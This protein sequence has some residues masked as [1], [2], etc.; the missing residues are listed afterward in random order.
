M[1]TSQP[2]KAGRRR[3]GFRREARRECYWFY[4]GLLAAFRSARATKAHK[5]TPSDGMASMTTG[6]IAGIPNVQPTAKKA[7]IAAR[8]MYREETK[9]WL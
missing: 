8:A 3:I 5:A 9:R 1:I 2:W 4:W 6:A 7:P